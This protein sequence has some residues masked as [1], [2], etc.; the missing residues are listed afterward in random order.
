MAAANSTTNSNSEP[1]SKPGNP[2]KAKRERVLE[3]VRATHIELNQ[4][5]EKALVETARGLIRAASRLSGAAGSGGG[6]K[7]VS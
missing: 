6:G 7:E 1:A 2:G 4:P 3:E 5:S